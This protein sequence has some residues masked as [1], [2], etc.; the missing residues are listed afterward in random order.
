MLPERQLEALSLTIS[1]AEQQVKAAV[2]LDRDSGFLNANTLVIKL[3]V[4]VLKET[5]VREYS[6]CKQVVVYTILY[7]YILAPAA[8]CLICL[9]TTSPVACSQPGS[10]IKGNALAYAKWRYG[11]NIC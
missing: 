7:N 10:F 6:M 3:T 5:E 11:L 9:P 4:R 2:L 1:R 8:H